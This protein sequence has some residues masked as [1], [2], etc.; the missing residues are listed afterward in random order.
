MLLL[1]SNHFLISLVLNRDIFNENIDHLCA[2]INKR[3]FVPNTY[4]QSLIIDLL[5]QGLKG[6]QMRKRKVDKRMRGI[7]M[8]NFIQYLERHCLSSSGCYKL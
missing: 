3:K 1:G 5:W 7:D 2:S 4:I 8:Y 6:L